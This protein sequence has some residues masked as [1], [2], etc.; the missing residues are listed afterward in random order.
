MEFIP[1]ERIE[2]K[3]FELLRTYSNKY[4]WEISLPIPI[5]L[6]NLNC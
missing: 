1:D 4:N 2:R 3:A 6:I 5:E